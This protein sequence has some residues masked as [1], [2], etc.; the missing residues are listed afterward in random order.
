MSTTGGRD[1]GE[2]AASAPTRPSVR[3][4]LAYAGLEQLP[5]VTAVAAYAAGRAAMQAGTGRRWRLPVA[6]IAWDSAYWFLVLLLLAILWHSASFLRDELRSRRLSGR[7]IQDRAIEGGGSEARRP[8]RRWLAHVGGRMGLVQPAAAGLTVLLVVL[9][10]N[11]FVA[12]KTAI[13]ALHPFTWDPALFRADR[14]LHLGHD[15]WRLLRPLLN[16]PGAVRILDVLYALWFVVVMAVLLWQCWSSERR[17]RCRFLLAF[18]LCWT[19]GGSVLAVIFSSAGPVYYGRV[20]GL[21]DPYRPLL[22]HL[23]SMDSVHSLAALKIQRYLWESYTGA[24]VHS[25][26][27]ISAMPSMHVSMAVL[28]ALVGTERSRW[29]GG[30]LWVFAA[31]IFV[32][33]VLL[34]WHYAVDGYAA[35]ALTLGCWWVA[36]LLTGRWDSVL[37]RPAPRG[38]V[39]ASLGLSALHR[40]TW[41]SGRD[42]APPAP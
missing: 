36:R 30:L 35:V 28:A 10:L 17:T 41:G 29:L 7:Q 20:T 3:G 27:G 15:P 8:I 33:S 42:A 19:V 21:P 23:A 26:Q 2:P 14:M 11:L 37:S 38:G 16:A 25:V 31:G 32:G 18:L 39:R 6:G 1:P 13:P 22:H 4:R 9:F 12:V 34:G 40:E 5:L 24:A